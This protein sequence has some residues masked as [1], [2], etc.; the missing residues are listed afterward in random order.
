METIKVKRIYKIK[1]TK[2]KED[3]DGNN[4]NEI[5][6]SALSK[7]ILVYCDLNG[8]EVKLLDLKDVRS[9]SILKIKSTRDNYKKLIFELTDNKYC[10]SLG[11]TK[12]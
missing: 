4:Y 9:Q 8:I 11:R 7:M 3:Y 12:L 2:N 1:F 5:R 6:S 10:I